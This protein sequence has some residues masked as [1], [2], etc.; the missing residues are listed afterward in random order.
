M[1]GAMH[2]DYMKIKITIAILL[3]SFKVLGQTFDPSKETVEK[4]VQRRVDLKI[5]KE[6]VYY[7]PVSKKG[8]TAKKGMLR[9][10]T[11]YNKWGKPTHNSLYLP[12][13]TIINDSEYD[14]KGRETKLTNKDGQGQI[15]QILVFEYDEMNELVRTKYFDKNGTLTSTNERNMDNGSVS[16]NSNG[17]MTSKTTSK[18]DSTERSYSSVLLSTTGQLKYE[19]KYFFNEKGQIV[20]WSII[21]NIRNKRSETKYVYDAN[22]NKIE[23]N[24]FSING[25][26]IKKYL[27]SYN[28]KNLMTE[29]IVFEPYDKKKQVLKYEYEF[30]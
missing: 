14:E 18:Y 5:N 6:T 7:Y 25:V 24:E 22:G 13:M 16:S 29:W 1:L 11:I 17:D 21:D 4:M 8:K 9:R 28:E 19:N 30:Y 26:P 2:L 20:L 27:Y 23:E 10:E 15:K 3:F 12:N